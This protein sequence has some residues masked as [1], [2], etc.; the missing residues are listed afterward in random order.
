MNLKFS[1]TRALILGGSCGLAL[2]LAEHMIN[3]GL[4]PILTC[5]SEKS[6]DKI[7]DRLKNFRGKYSTARLDFSDRATL[8]S[9]FEQLDHDL[10]FLVD[11]VHG[12]FESLV[13]SAGED[14]VY[15]YFSENI[16]FR[17]GVIKQAARIMLAK[18]RGRC[19][20]ISSS[21]AAKPNPGQG[22]YAA[23][24]VASEVLYKNLGLELGERGITTVT[25][26]P[27]Y[28]DEGRGHEYLQSHGKEALE[29][30]P[31]KK[32]LSV[33]GFAETIMFYLSESAK[34]FN[35]VEIAVDGGLTA[36]K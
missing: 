4:F 5:R 17:A 15:R 36:G 9:L 25:L 27:G 11:F 16:S 29:K 26:R 12:N 20:F 28:I 14:D 18:R 32:A 13:A 21:A 31:T 19:I 1:G 8:A 24:K 30:V 3:A 2:S 23:A 6:L 33:K 7:S 35:A 10:D 34:D 22:F